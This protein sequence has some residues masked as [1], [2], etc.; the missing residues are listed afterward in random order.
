MGKDAHPTKKPK[1]NPYHLIGID[2]SSLAEFPFFSVTSNAARDKRQ[3]IRYERELVAA[4]RK[5]E[6]IIEA[7]PL[8]GMPGVHDA[9]VLLALLGI[10]NENRN[11]GQFSRT[12]DTQR[13]IPYSPYRL[14]RIMQKATGGSQYR[15][16]RDSAKRWQKT[17]IECNNWYNSRNDQYREVSFSFFSYADLNPSEADLSPA[18]RLSFDAVKLSE[19][20]HQ[21]VEDGFNK[22]LDLGHYFSLKKPTSKQAFRFFDKRLRPRRKDWFD[23]HDFCLVHLGMTK[24]PATRLIDRLQPCVMELEARRL[25][26]PMPYRDR[27]VRKGFGKYD[28]CFEGVKRRLSTLS[29]AAIAL[30]NEGVNDQTAIAIAADARYSEEFIR[31]QIELMH[32]MVESPDHKTPGAPAG[33]LVEA[34]RNDYIPPK[35]FKTAAEKA[36]EAAARFRAE[37]EQVKKQ[38]EGR[39]QQELFKQERQAERDKA[40]RE[41]KEVKSRLDSLPEHVREQ[42]ITDAIQSEGDFIVQLVTREKDRKGGRWDYDSFIF[43]DTIKKHFG[44]VEELN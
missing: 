30:I 8:Y 9:D 11:R 32:H 26:A 29:P 36:E 20:F 5:Q 41:W 13:V 3:V 40:A 16:I 10:Y 38:M 28:V 44:R 43:Q 15:Q 12:P 23:L 22:D 1:A 21:M 37:E 2:D 6:I 24:A 31:R 27:F 4:K 19:P 35:D 25:I 18:E 42:F 39:R 17:N 33:Y 34:I 7:S 14:C